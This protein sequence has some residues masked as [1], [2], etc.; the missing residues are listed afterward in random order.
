M[1]EPKVR[2][3]F[4]LMILTVLVSVSCG[5]KAE[6]TDSRPT[7]TVDPVTGELEAQLK[8]QSVICEAGLSCPS[9]MAKIAIVDNNKLKF[10]TGFLVNSVTLATASSCL[11]ETLR[12][13]EDDTR[14][15]KDL[16][17]FFPRSGFSGALRVGCQ[18]LFYA[19]PIQGADPVL[20]RQDVAYIELSEPVFR[21][22]VRLSRQGL[23]NAEKLTV[24]KIDAD[25]N[26]LGVIRKNEC[27]VIQKSYV[28]PL[29]DTDSNPT[30]LISG[31]AFKE[32]NAGALIL[33]PQQGWRGIVSRPLS[34]A[35]ERV[36][37]QNEVEPLQPILH[38]SNGA[39]LQSILESDAPT[40]RECFRNLDNDEIDAR[41]ADMLTNLSPY[42]VNRQAVEAD[43][44]QIRPY[45]NWKADLVEDSVNGGYE[46]ELTPVCMRP[47]ADWIDLVGRGT[48]RFVYSKIVPR[49]KLTLGFDRGARLV[50]RLDV[51]E[52][53]KI[54]VQFFPRNAWNVKRTDMFVWKEGMPSRSFEDIKACE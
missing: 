16:H 54:Y 10:C 35:L 40:A 2:S 14:C 23:P 15:Q 50:S 7:P 48:R 27:E 26:Q 24:W 13:S 53:Q 3:L 37:R 34:A 39:C 49:W 25:N 46:I 6:V 31:C 36:V 51:T 38:V 9:G 4:M 12:I 17:V 47:I 22:S 11:T 44:N 42:Q 1:I 19:S 41:R 28:N 18:K 8:Q 20:W 33:G 32:G 21:R 29:F 43:V 45:F 5:K 30:A 52:S